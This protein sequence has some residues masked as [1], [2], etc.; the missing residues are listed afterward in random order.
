MLRWEWGGRVEEEGRRRVREGVVDSGAKELLL[1]R[2]LPKLKKFLVHLQRYLFTKP[3]VPADIEFGVL[4]LYGKLDSMLKS[5]TKTGQAGGQALSPFARFVSWKDTHEAV[6]KIELQEAAE[7]KQGVKEEEVVEEEEEE[8]LVLMRVCGQSS[9]AV[10]VSSAA[11]VS[12][13]AV[14]FVGA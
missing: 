6:V 11:C 8:W 1:P 14:P 13:S 10:G 2:A 4:D 12:S 9:G 5:R 7:A 3:V